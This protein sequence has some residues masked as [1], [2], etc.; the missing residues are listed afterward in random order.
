MT[1]T[2][3]LVHSGDKYE[4]VWPYWYYYWKQNWRAQAYVD[5]VFLTETAPFPWPGVIHATCGAGQ[6]WADGLGRVIKALPPEVRY[7][8]YQHEDYFYDEPTWTADLL[9]LIECVKRY[10]MKLLKCCG[11]WAGYMDKDHPMTESNIEVRIRGKNERIWHYPNESLYLVSHQ[12]SIWEREFLF[13]SLFTQETPWGHE[14][15]GTKRVRQWS[16]P[17]YAYRGKC[18]MPYAETITH[19]GIRKGFEKWFEQPNQEANTWASKVKTQ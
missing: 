2:I 10:D 6:P 3:V 14:I 15:N 5:T 12:T 9:A 4:W 19:G 17:I 16:V 13:K 7:I 8:I 18:P 11:W 1:D